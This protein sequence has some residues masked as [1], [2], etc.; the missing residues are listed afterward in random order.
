LEADPEKTKLAYR[1]EGSVG[2]ARAMTRVRTDFPFHLRRRPPPET[3]RTLL[4]YSD[5]GGES[6]AC[7]AAGAIRVLVRIDSD[8]HEAPSIRLV[9]LRR[10]VSGGSAA[11]DHDSSPSAAM[12]DLAHTG[13]WRA[14]MLRANDESSRG[15]PP[16]CDPS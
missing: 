7:R 11:A 6:T 5:C 4:R 10:L 9:V 8:A 14:A 3:P 12:C 13:L 15:I 2:I 16:G 1:C